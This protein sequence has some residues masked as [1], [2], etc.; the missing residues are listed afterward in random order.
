MGSTRRT[1]MNC[2]AKVYLRMNEIIA[3]RDTATTISRLFG[4]NEEVLEGE[5]F[6]CGDELQKERTWMLGNADVS[7]RNRI[8]D[9]INMCKILQGGVRTLFTSK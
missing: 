7:M 5:V 2:L 4:K 6:S 8:I 1:S 9:V 3:R